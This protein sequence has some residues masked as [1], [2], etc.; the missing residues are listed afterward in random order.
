VALFQGGEVDRVVCRHR[1]I[2]VH[3]QERLFEVA[4]IGRVDFAAAEG[5]EPSGRVT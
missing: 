3:R 5:L 2:P 1:L 4:P